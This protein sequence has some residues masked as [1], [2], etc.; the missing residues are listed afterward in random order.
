[1]LGRSSRYLLQGFRSSCHDSELHRGLGAVQGT[2]G[3]RGC[4]AARGWEV[5]AEGVQECADARGWSLCATEIAA[6][7]LSSPGRCGDN[8]C[9]RTGVDDLKKD[10]VLWAFHPVLI[11]G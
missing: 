7:S 5:G 4:K 11:R 6:V 10:L 3:L 2:L 9:F 8:S 1:M